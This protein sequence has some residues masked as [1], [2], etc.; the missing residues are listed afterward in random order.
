MT[1]EWLAEFQFISISPEIEISVTEN[2]LW[3]KKKININQP[4]T[5]K[6]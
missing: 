2:K 3:M 5:D 6:V 4:S 1:R